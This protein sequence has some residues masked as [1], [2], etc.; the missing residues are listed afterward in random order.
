MYVC[1]Y[2]SHPPS[3]HAC[4]GHIF[5]ICMPRK[6]VRVKATT[7]KHTTLHLRDV[8]ERRLDVYMVSPPS[9]PLHL[10]MPCTPE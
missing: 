3:I 2:N 6:S 7:M 4:I 8:G 5:R 9:S 1:T 10:E